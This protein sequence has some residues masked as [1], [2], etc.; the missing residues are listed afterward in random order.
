MECKKIY[1]YVTFYNST[2]YNKKEN[3]CYVVHATNNYKKRRFKELEDLDEEE[4]IKWV[5][6]NIE[7]KCIGDLCMGK[8]LVAY[9]SNLNEKK[10]VGIELNKKR[11]AVAVKRITTVNRNVGGR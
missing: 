1:K 11:L 10:Y 5:T 4:I 8:G 2:Y 9:Y 3:K 7:Y 6:K